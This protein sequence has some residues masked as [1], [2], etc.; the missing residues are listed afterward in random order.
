MTSRLL[1]ESSKLYTD[2]DPFEVS[3]YVNQHVGNHRLIL[4]GKSKPSA[5]LH[6]RKAGGI[7]LCRLSYG[8]Q[9]NVRSEG[10]KGIY[11]IQFILKGH[12]KYKLRD[13]LFSLYAGE[14][15][16]INADEPIDLTYSEDCEKFIVRIP[17]IS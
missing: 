5:T 11:H 8:T 3:E 16:V 17:L 15:L 1:E 10:L 14:F 4:N 2:A 7:D 9:A 13:E 6:H 12:C